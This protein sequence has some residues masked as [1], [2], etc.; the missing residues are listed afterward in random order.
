MPMWKNRPGRTGCAGRPAPEAESFVGTEGRQ[1]EAAAGAAAEV[2]EEDFEDGA[3]LPS[4][5]DD[6]EDGFAAGLLPVSTDDDEE[7]E[8]VR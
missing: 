7:R 8:S 4:E 1:A 5:P 6:V 3:V 2:P